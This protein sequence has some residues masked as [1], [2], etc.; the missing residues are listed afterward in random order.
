MISFWSRI[1]DLIAPRSC[2]I[3]GSRLG[4]EEQHICARCNLHLPRTGFASDAYENE[5]AR[6]FW[7]RLPMERAA[8]LY[9]Y[10]SHAPAAEPIYELKYHRRP[11]IGVELGRLMAEDFA[12]EGFFEGIDLLLPVPLTT[13]RRRQR[14]YNQSREIARGVSQVTG[15]PVADDALLRVAFEES[16]TLK[17][18]WQRAENV[19]GVFKLGKN[20]DEI[21]GK[22]VL[23]VDDV[24]TTGA[25]VGACGEALKAVEGIKIS[26]LS[27]AFAKS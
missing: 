26:V 13:K 3:C 9:Y 10:Q 6:L 14:G 12:R 19:S 5:M 27:V 16:Q 11:E 18:R 15:I 24:V 8:A 22:H 21:A 25:T 2:V 1:S 20:A 23:I 7:G 4:I 17:D